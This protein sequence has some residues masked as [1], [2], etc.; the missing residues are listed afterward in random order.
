MSPKFIDSRRLQY[1][2]S[3]L[4]RPVLADVTRGGLVHIHHPVPKPLHYEPSPSPFSNLPSSLLG[5]S[6]HL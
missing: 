1:W 5:H 4:I 2:K 6:Y 3:F